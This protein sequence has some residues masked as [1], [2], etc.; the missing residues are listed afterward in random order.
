VVVRK[1]FIVAFR[2]LVTSAGIQPREESTLVHV[3]DTAR[4]TAA[5]HPP[6]FD[7]SVSRA[8][9][10]PSVAPD[11]RQQDISLNPNRRVEAPLKVPS[12]SSSFHPGWNSQ[13]RIATDTPAD[14]IPRL[15]QGFELRITLDSAFATPP[16][17]RGRRKRKPN[18]SLFLLCLHLSCPQSYS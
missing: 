2:R 4:M 10:T 8:P 11:V 5:L 17:Q 13:G 9:T 3:A 18:I 6:P 15:S 7:D 16:Q 14:V 1:G 12:P